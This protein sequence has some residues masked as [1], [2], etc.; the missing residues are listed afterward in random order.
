MKFAR[1]LDRLETKVRETRSEISDD[2][3]RARFQV[4]LDSIRARMSVAPEKLD[5]S[6]MSVIERLAFGLISLAEL[7]E[8]LHK[9]IGVG[10]HA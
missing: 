8:I 1:R 7:R 4:R 3:L 9:Q 2:V 6:Q 5:P 10:H